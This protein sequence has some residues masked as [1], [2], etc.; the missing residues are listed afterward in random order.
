MLDDILVSLHD[1]PGVQATL[2]IDSG[3]AL[4]AHRSHSIYDLPLL[5]Q[6]GRGLIG[7]T[8]SMQ[9]VHEDWE[10]VTASFADGKVLIRNLRPA[11]KPERTV[12]L[13]VIADSQLNRS[14]AGVAMRVAAG[15]LKAELEAGGSPVQR[16]A[17]VANG[18]A[19]SL[20]APAVSTSH[21]RPP[22]R[23]AAPLASAP[24]P[25]P[26]PTNGDVAGSGLTWSVN[27]T[28]SATSSGVAVED[29]SA[30]AFLAACTKALSASVGPMAKV[31]VKE[32]VRK[33][34]ADRAFSRE[35]GGALVTELSRCVEDADDLVEFQRRMQ[36]A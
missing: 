10:S 33:V 30:S 32:A 13:A 12:L 21:A 17:H 18:T 36:S 25:L 1:V 26:P 28:S 8:D 22:V 20:S 31:F 14:F 9:V 2:V 15:K 27:V 23:P 19:P 7:A 3:G 4:L 11:L 16:V 5:Q 34:C 35:D 24:L 29:A 6:V